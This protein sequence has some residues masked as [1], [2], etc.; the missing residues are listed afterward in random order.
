MLLEVDL[1]A[2]RTLLMKNSG[3]LAE[4]RDRVNDYHLLLLRLFEG[5]PELSELCLEEIECKLINLLLK[6]LLV[7]DAS[8][9]SHRPPSPY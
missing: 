3:H 8:F 9:V 2:E 4:Q 1:E 6:G 7:Y 5:S